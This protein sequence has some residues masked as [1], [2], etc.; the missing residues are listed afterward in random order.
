M[1][2]I[3]TN[4]LQFDY[5]TV[6]AIT[7]VVLFLTEANNYFYAN[8][9]VITFMSTLQK[10]RPFKKIIKSENIFNITLFL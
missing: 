8:M 4:S 6:T 10:R 9:L 1:S 3:I 5:N 2:V 7:I